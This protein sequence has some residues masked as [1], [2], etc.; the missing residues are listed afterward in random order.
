MSLVTDKP[1]KHI[2]VVDDAADN[3][4]LVQFILETEGYQV[5]AAESGELALKFIEAKIV[6]PDLIILD[7]M[8]PK[9]NG[10]EVIKSLRDRHELPR[11]PVLLMTANQ[12]VSDD[13]ARAAGADGIF[14]KPLDLEEFLRAVEL[15][16]TQS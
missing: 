14:Y 6:K 12:D 7:L 10:Y 9:M 4:F 3:I 8:M 15:F 16:S 1:K 11:I 2:L 13:R 5:D